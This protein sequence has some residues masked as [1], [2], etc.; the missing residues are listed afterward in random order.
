MD[1][2]VFSLE[3]KQKFNGLVRRLLSHA[4]VAGIEKDD[5]KFIRNHI[6]YSL[7]NGLCQRNIHNINPIYHKLRTIDLLCSKVSP[8]KNISLAII[9]AELTEEGAISVSEIGKRYGDDIL[10]LVNGLL[11]VSIT[12]KK[13]G[14]FQQ[15]SITEAAREGQQNEK[16]KK[17]SEENFRKMMLTFAE[18]LR[19]II[20]MIIDWLNLMYTINNNT[21]QK[22]VK[23]VVKEAETLYAPLAHRLGLYTIKS[24]LEDMSLKYK[25][26]D[27]YNQIAHDLKQTKNKRDAYIASFIAPVKKRLSE[28]GYKFEIKGRTKSIS[29]IQN[30]LIKQRTVIEKIFDLFAIRIILDSKPEN[31]I[32]DCWAVFSEITNMYTPNPDRT[33]DWLTIR[34]SNGYQSLHTT[35]MG[36]ENRWVEVQIRT[37]R[38]DEVAEKGIAAHWLYKGV[39]KDDELDEWMKN[40]RDVLDTAKNHPMELIKDLKIDVYDQEVFAFSPKG[41]VVKL[42]LGASVLDFA[43]AIHSNLGSKCTGGIVNGKNQKISHKVNNGDIIEILTSP[44][45]TPKLD[46][47]NFVITSKARNKIRTTIKEMNSKSAELG[48]E[49]ISRRFKNR[50]IEVSESKLTRVIKRMGY[51]TNTTFYQAIAKEAIDPN[52]IIALYETIDVKTDEPENRSADTFVMQTDTDDSQSDNVLVIGSSNLKGLNYKLAKCCN[53]IYGDDVFGFISSEGIVKVHK[54]NCPNAAHIHQRYPYRIITT[55]WSGKIGSQ[56]A[57]TLRVVGQ[58]DIGIVTNISSIIN[59]ENNVSLRSISIDSHDGLF[60]GYLVV[61]VS[62]KQTL[63]NLIKKIKTV[64]GVKDVERS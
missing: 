41:K 60:Q 55:R 27:V 6:V 40:V 34:K 24:E 54:S 59:K 12:Y 46:W 22:Y 43:F 25:E 45:Q 53:P 32:K 21:D 7:E 38:M 1:I 52:D 48:K 8:D 44:N 19:V 58:D 3:E 29:S 16:M 11:K 31:E 9:L 47:L 13:S 2:S 30:K 50:K 37:K 23:E 5:I 64:K 4:K 35:V 28:L 36:P 63:N 61:G 17:E 15:N 56:F 20:I 62:D 10:S 57:A 51:K 42:P 26:R 49:L 18:D 33:K 14:K 39:K